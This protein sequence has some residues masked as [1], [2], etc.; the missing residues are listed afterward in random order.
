MTTDAM[1]RTVLQ[2]SDLTEQV[3][4]GYILL[5]PPGEGIG[6]MHIDD[7]NLTETT[8]TAMAGGRVVAVFPIRADWRIL[9][10]TLI[11]KMTFEDSMRVSADAKKATDALR[12]EIMPDLPER[13]IEDMVMEQLTG[14]QSAKAPG[15]YL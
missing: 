15:Q 13:S 9:D 8:M 7:W 5:P 14:R 10:S 6:Y 1:K 4:R 2:M 12:K 3:E 11:T